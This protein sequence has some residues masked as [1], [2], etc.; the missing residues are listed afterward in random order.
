MGAREL[1][2]KNKPIIL[3]EQHTDDFMNGTS[4]VVDYLREL[5]YKFL[6]VENSFYFGDFFLFQFFGLIMRSILGYKLMLIERD[7]FKN[8]FYS[9]I[10]AVPN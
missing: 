8:R 5:N 4:N 9:M 10:V 6:T 1:I 2:R 7:Y 3:F